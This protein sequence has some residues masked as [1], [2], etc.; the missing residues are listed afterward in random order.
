MLKIIDQIE[1]NSRASK[2]FALWLINLK[3]GTSSSEEFLTTNVRICEVKTVVCMS[4]VS[5]VLRKLDTENKII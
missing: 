4:W 1:M 3:V 5:E 2:I